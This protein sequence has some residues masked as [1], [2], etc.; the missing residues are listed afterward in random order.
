M[1]I[2]LSH[3]SGNSNVRAIAKT[4]VDKGVLGKFYTSIATFPNSFWY[5]CAARGPLKD[6]RRRTYHN[7]LKSVTK[8]YPWRELGR[9]F[10]SK[11]GLENL[12]K[13][14]EGPFCVDKVY[15]ELD[16][17]VAA[18]LKDEQEQGATAVYAYEDGALETFYRAKELG[19]TCIYE[20]PIAYW[21]TGRRLMMEEAVR[22]PQ[23]SETLGGGIID[24]KSKLQRKKLELQLADVVIGPGS[25]VMDSLPE[26][27][28]NKKQ[29]ISP[30]GSPPITQ[31]T[32]LYKPYKVD[33]NSPL[34]V[35]FVGSMGQRKGLGDLF[36]AMKLLKNKNIELVVLGSM[37][38]SMEF[39]R[40]EFPDFT[41]ETCREHSEVLAL[42]LS[43]DVFCLP[44]IVEG[45][46][47]VL[48]EAMSQGLPL[49]ITPNTGGADLIKEGKT[50]FLVPIRSP[51]KIAEKLEWFLNNRLKIP[52]MGEHSRTLAKSY[53][54]EKYGTTIYR[55][56]LQYF[57]ATSGT[58]KS[59]NLGL[60]HAK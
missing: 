29:V 52:E 46:A 56:L 3:P 2:I 30:F 42:M 26:W 20:L 8:C 47:L 9:S 6:F 12:I 25:F 10:S 44:S 54:W 23:W 59:M 55:A 32:D 15:Q 60:I 19:L 36:A 16:R 35:L 31:E 51:E 58:E 50:G 18:R 24:S 17:Y 4:M 37:L 27:A 57:D 40:K 39:Y 14:E 43:C 45:R 22:L 48:Q 13:H 53:S 41:Y 1:K 21:K 7:D 49:I 28:K 34:R 11:F 38:S 5:T 33:I